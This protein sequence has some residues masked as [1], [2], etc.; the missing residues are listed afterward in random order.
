VTVAEGTISNL[1][2]FLEQGANPAKLLPSLHD[3]HEQILMLAD[4]INDLGTLS[5]AQRGVDNH[6][7][8]VNVREFCEA[9][10]A[11]MH[12]V[13][14]KKGL[15]FD[16]DIEPRVGA[17]VTSQLYLQEMLQNFVTNAIKYSEKGGVTLSAHHE[18]DTVVFAVK[19]TGIGISKTDQKRVFE[20]F[21]RSEDYR[22]R[23]SNGTGL[24]LYV[25]AKLARML[26]TRIELKSRLNHGSTFSFTLPRATSGKS[27]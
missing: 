16:L 12:P 4:L 21:Y 9:I 10:Y 3:A 17:V 24:G 1:Q 8:S 11:D 14:V 15:T 27:D 26:G 13:A 7:E 2:Y 25:V 22:T 23:A 20:K 19:D 5:R 6:T 18:A